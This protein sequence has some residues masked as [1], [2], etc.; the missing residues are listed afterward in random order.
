MLVKILKMFVA[1]FA[2][3][4]TEKVAAR[5]GETV[6]ERVAERLG[7]L[8]ESDLALPRGVAV[9]PKGVRSYEEE[10][11]GFFLHLLPGP[12]RDDG[13]P[14][15]I[16]FW[17]TRIED[18]NETFRI[19]LVYGPSGC[20]KSSFVKAGLMP[21]L[22]TRHVTPIYI[23]TT[24]TETVGR[25]LVALKKHCPYLLARSSLRAALRRKRNVPSGQKV[26]L[27]LDQF[28]QYLHGASVDEQNA[29]ADALGECDG[30]TLQCVLAV[31]DDFITQATLFINRLG[32]RLS[33]SDNSMLVPLLEKR[34]AKKVLALFGQAFGALPR[35]GL[36][37]RE[38]EVFLDAA[39]DG[40]A[41][42]DYVV[43]VRLSVFSEM[44]RPKDWTP[45]TLEAIGGIQGVG[46]SF[47][48]ESFVATT[49]PAENRRHRKAAEA[50]LDALLPEHGTM[51]KETMV[52]RSL[53]LRKSGY[54][55]RPEA[56][57]QLLR[58]L[59]GQLRLITPVIHLLAEQEAGRGWE[60]TQGETH[61]H[62][63]HDYLVQP[64]RTWLACQ[65]TSSFAGR[66]K[67]ALTE[68]CELW[69]A[70]GRKARHLLPWLLRIKAL[71]GTSP[72][73]VT[74]TEAEYIRRSC[75]RWPL[76]LRIPLV[77]LRFGALGLGALLLP[78]FA[79]AAFIVLRSGCWHFSQLGGELFTLGLL[80]A[81]SLA[82]FLVSIRSVLTRLLWQMWK[83]SWPIRPK[84]AVLAASLLFSL[85]LP[86]AL[87]CWPPMRR[88]AV[89]FAEDNPELQVRVLSEILY[90][91][92]REP[93]LRCERA[94]A[95]RCLGNYEAALADFDHAVADESA[96][97]WK[98][99]YLVGSTYCQISLGRYDDALASCIRATELDPSNQAAYTAKGCILWC[100][101]R[102]EDACT[103]LQTAWNLSPPPSDTASDVEDSV[104]AGVLLACLL[105]RMRQPDAARSVAEALLEYPL[106]GEHYWVA[107]HFA[108]LTDKGGSLVWAAEKRR[109]S[110]SLS[111]FALAQEALAANDWERAKRQLVLSTETGPLRLGVWAIV[112]T[113]LAR[114]ETIS[115]EEATVLDADHLPPE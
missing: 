64:V 105:V 60:S 73:V 67:L 94:E 28:E 61:Y 49:A 100:F 101:G 10:D 46:V 68:S 22:D 113:Q 17:R 52:P 25:L 109:L 7:A 71:L 76:A 58:I 72:G 112:Y 62:L 56:F 39:I 5:V 87:L 55:A 69:N 93:S 85:A 32:I 81:I 110:R 20:G 15:S 108:G 96:S 54:S 2:R 40:L 74:E 31:R 107:H 84:A 3:V 88:G 104:E 12:R 78:L 66:A 24:P 1:P 86:V 111:S 21:R 42:R 43:P 23:E 29:L 83:W 90:F 19:G 44:V 13:S 4:A 30:K 48:E 89:T 8:V 27:I 18:A 115:A 34:H 95:Y 35:T 33:Q 114:V 79:Y 16:H 26:L 91:E 45:A 99:A 14:E 98:S 41:E 11:A 103:S 97:E 80:L 53:L 106:E 77:L 37:N 50:V 92:P 38:Q 36:L 65:A 63:T 57:E 51:L 70:A 6:G 82:L 47:L 102:K 9:V 75:L 59:D